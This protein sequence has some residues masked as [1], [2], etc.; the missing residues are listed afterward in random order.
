MSSS[1]SNK[2]DSPAVKAKN[3]PRRIV[4]DSLG[5]SNNVL[6][7]GTS[8]VLKIGK[9]ESLLHVKADGNDIHGISASIAHDLFYRP[10]L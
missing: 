3:G 10:L 1:A 6:I 4:C 5:E 2:G 8:D 9:D 7:K